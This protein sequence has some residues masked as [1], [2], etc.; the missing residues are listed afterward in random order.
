MKNRNMMFESD[1][2]TLNEFL[3]NL[4]EENKKMI[5]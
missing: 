3:N 2:G 4:T 1:M 5:E